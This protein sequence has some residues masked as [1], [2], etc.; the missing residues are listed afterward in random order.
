MVVV[1]VD[2]M[3]RL[4]QAILGEVAD[5][6]ARDTGFILRERGFS[7]YEFVRVL[8]LGWLANPNASIESL[9]DEL[10]ISG[11]ALQQ[12]LTESASECLRSVLGAAVAQCLGGPAARIPLLCRVTG[13]Y[14]EDCS[15]ISLPE[16]LARKVGP[17]S[18]P[19]NSEAAEAA[20]S[21][22]ASP[23]CDCLRLTN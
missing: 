13:V 18:W 12:R 15:T 19:G 20:T 17:K 21:T 8:T 10:G 14:A 16:A 11:S 9:A 1:V 3:S 4:L 22:R 23:P 5:E 6:A 7:G 2:K